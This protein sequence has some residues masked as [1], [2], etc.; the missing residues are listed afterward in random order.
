MKCKINNDSSFLLEGELD[1]NANKF[2][3][4]N[5]DI[6]SLLLDKDFLTGELET[7][8]KFTAI[9][10]IYIG[11][12]RSNK[13]KYIITKPKFIIKNTVYNNELEFKT[14]SIKFKINNLN[15]NFMD[16]QNS[17]TTNINFYNKTLIINSKKNEFILKSKVNIPIEEMLSYISLLN[18]F[19][20]ILNQKITTI[21]DIYIKK[22]ND[23]YELFFDKFI[24]FN[25]NNMQDFSMI[26]LSEI[27]KDFNSILTN[28]FKFEK[29]YDDFKYRCFIHRILSIPDS[30]FMDQKFLNMTTTIE[31]YFNRFHYHDK[32]QYDEYN[33]IITDNNGKYKTKPLNE[34]IKLLILKI[35][36]YL[37]T[38]LID[39]NNSNVDKWADNVRICRNIFAHGKTKKIKLTSKELYYTIEAISNLLL[40]ALLIELGFS[41]DIL[42]EISNSYGLINYSIENLN[43][44]ILK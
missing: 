42:L 40:I 13:D 15:S 21:S 23:Y 18:E 30:I 41:N 29:K 5:I 43:T 16:L 7:G 37:E 36:N 6:T 26:Q 1:F 19:L 9:K 38:P 8:E 32:F 44:F 27:V 17:K 31:Y 10:S 20:T 24:V 35:N 12:S 3:I 4:F 11:G 28:L 25:R 39:L 2:K 34:L 22:D 33:N 14:N